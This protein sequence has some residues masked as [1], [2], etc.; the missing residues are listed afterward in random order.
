LL[1]SLTIHEEAGI[2]AIRQKSLAQTDYLIDLIEMTGLCEAPYRYRI[3]TPRDHSRRGG[4][5]AIEHD[6]AA[7]IAQALKARGIVVDFRP[8]DVARIAPV[9]LY[10]TW[11]EVWQTVQ[12]LRE[13]ID[14]AEHRNVTASG[15]VT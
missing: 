10:T 3:G 4:H 12:A 1:G 7:N 8:P 14:G 15:L 2:V 11:L 6:R 13:I 5:V 9:A